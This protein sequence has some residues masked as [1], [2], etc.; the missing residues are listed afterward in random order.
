LQIGAAPPPAELAVA[1]DPV[2]G[3]SVAVSPASLRLEHAGR[4][5]YFCAPGCR[6]AFAAD[7]ARYGA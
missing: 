4:T 5:W 7:P 6:T 2:C 1:T 3:M